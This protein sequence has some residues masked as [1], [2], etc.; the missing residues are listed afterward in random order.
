MKTTNLNKALADLVKKFTE[1]LEAQAKID[2]TNATGKFAKSFK[3]EVTKEGFEIYSDAKYAGSVN[4]GAGAARSSREG[5]DKKRRLE[6]WALAKGI[7][8]L[9]KT[10]N[11]YKFRKMNTDSNSAFKS[12]IFAISK[13]IAK[14]GTIKRYQYKGSE[15]FDRVFESMRKKVGL[16]IKDGFSADLRDELIKIVKINGNLKK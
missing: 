1:K 11:G 4:S 3:G 7:R 9:T 12:M 6:E 15:I 2:R 8:P 5:Y 14:K 10:K 16:D 13:S